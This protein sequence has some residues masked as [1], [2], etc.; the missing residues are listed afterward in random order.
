MILSKFDGDWLLLFF[1][2]LPTRGSISTPSQLRQWCSQTGRDKML[3]TADV[4]NQKREVLK[5][6]RDL[7][8]KEYVS[9]PKEF[10]FAL[11][12]KTIDDEI[13]DYTY[14]IERERSSLP[15]VRP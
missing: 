11:A 3:A 6:K 14:K 2:H 10:R 5:I 15:T 9:H 4:W 12:I 1:H 7:L 13:A 8:F